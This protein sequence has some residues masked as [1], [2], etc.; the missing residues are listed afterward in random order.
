MYNIENDIFTYTSNMTTWFTEPLSGYNPK[1]QDSKFEILVLSLRSGGGGS[2]VFDDL[3]LGETTENVIATPNHGQKAI[4]FVAGFIIIML[5]HLY[6][7]TMI[8]YI[9]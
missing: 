8:P 1:E 3:C 5:S 6:V 7:E 4:Y 9:Y 2:N